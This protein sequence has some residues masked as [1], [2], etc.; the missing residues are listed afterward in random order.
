[1]GG[2]GRGGGPAAAPSAQRPLLVAEPRCAPL[3]QEVEAKKRAVL[4]G[5]VVSSFPKARKRSLNTLD[6]MNKK[7]IWGE[8]LKV[9][10][11]LGHTRS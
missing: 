2:A 11:N 1:M 7:R 4:A 10:E 6:V 8:R 5:F 9:A 3:G